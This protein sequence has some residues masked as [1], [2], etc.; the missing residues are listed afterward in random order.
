MD[1]YG[2]FFPSD[3][4]VLFCGLV[5]EPQHQLQPAAV[6]G[7]SVCKRSLKVFFLFVCRRSQRYQQLNSSCLFLSFSAVC[8]VAGCELSFS[9][10]VFVNR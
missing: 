2:V 6:F 9:T 3:V 7:L 1:D 8:P 4:K 5:V 10:V